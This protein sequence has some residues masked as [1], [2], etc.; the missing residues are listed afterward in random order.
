[1]KEHL[2]LED[3]LLV[4]DVSLNGRTTLHIY[5][6]SISNMIMLLFNIYLIF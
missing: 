4:E 5:Y 3:T 1:M 6:A 2:V